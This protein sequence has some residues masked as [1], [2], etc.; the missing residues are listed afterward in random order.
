MKTLA[1]ALAVP[2]LILAWATGREAQAAPPSASPTLVMAE[3]PA[4]D[5]SSP[6]GGI[7]PMPD[8]AV[9]GAWCLGGAAASMAAVYAAGPSESA[10]LLTGAMHVASGSA[11]LFIPL[12]SILGG[13]S[14]ALAAAV[15]PAVSWAIEQKDT[16]A[17]SAAASWLSSPPD[18]VTYASAGTDDAG[19]DTAAPGVRAMTENE[20]QA[21]GCL[22]GALAGFGGA[23]ATSPSEVAMLSSGATTVV[24]STPILALGLLGTIVVSGCGIGTYAI[25]PIR[26]LFSNISA[27]GDS[28]FGEAAHR[29]FAWLG[30]EPAT[31]VAERENAQ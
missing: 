15:Q 17:A 14:C 22:A 24:S 1:I 23:L 27:I 29:V 30:G 10:M 3:A 31:R 26:A 8:S 21:S 19:T 28:L 2:L 12:L 6:A 20:V 25:L 5:A 16:I 11:V 13:G 9:T 4:G 18:T 7:D